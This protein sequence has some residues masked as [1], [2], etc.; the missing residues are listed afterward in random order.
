MRDGINIVNGFQHVLARGG[1]QHDPS[2]VAIGSV[3]VK[4]GGTPARMPDRIGTQ[5]CF[6]DELIPSWNSQNG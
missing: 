5:K 2:V 6:F 1:A 4:H 3:P